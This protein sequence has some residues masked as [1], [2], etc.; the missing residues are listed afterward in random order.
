ME[1]YILEA[2]G[3]HGFLQFMVDRKQMIDEIREEAVQA[4]PK[5]VQLSARVKLEKPASEDEDATDLT[6]HMNSKMETVYL[7]ER[8]TEDAFFTKFHQ[9]LSSLFSFTCPGSGWMLKD[10]NG[11]YV[12]LVP[13]VTI[14]DSSYHALLS[15]PQSMNC[16]LNIRN[17]EINNFFLY[18]Y[19]TA[20]HSTYAQSVYEN[21]GWRMRKN[22]EKYC[23]SNPMTHQ[24][25]GDLELPMAFNQILRF[26]NLTKVKL[27]YSVTNRKIKFPCEYWNDRNCHSF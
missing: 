16:L 27:M 24:P 20:C 1:T 19:V 23:P 17:R 14:R 9:L 18:C 21:V 15:D 4:E 5:K 3:D 12:K 6:I 22:Q 25:V 7:G 26:E 8:L 13:Y 11:L 10:I 2:N